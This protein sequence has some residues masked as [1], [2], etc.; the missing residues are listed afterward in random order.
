M[1]DA[2]DQLAQLAVIDGQL[3]QMVQMAET[4]RMQKA[5]TNTQHTQNH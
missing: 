2:A 1:E 4:V 3:S 5:A